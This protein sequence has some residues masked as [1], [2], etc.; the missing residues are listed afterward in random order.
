MKRIS[1]VVFVSLLLSTTSWSFT[2]YMTLAKDNCWQDYNV[3]VDIINSSTGGIIT[4]VNI[5]KGES[6]A[7]QTFDCEVSEKL[8]YIARF[9]PVFWQKDIGKTYPA[10]RFWSLPAQINPGDSAWNVSVCY[11]ADFSLV[12]TPPQATNNC[13]CDFTVIPAI[14]PKKIP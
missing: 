4:T 5:P 3:S 1:L 11:P 6:W 9:S 2:C 8:M 13:Q 12:P 7:R 10:Q 14:P